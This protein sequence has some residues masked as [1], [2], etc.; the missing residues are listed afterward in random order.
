MEFKIEV[1]C[2]NSE[3]VEFGNFTDGESYRVLKYNALEY[4]DLTLRDDRGLE[5]EAS[6][7]WFKLVKGD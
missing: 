3:S 2:V 4:Y 7:N 5:Y 6:S 1:E